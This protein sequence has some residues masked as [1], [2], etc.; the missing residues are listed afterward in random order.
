MESSTLTKK[1]NWLDKL[2]LNKWFW[3][4]FCLFF[5]CY[6]L[7]RSM[8]R[9]LP[10]ELPIYST[11]P[12]YKLIDE[13]G[14][15]FGS[16][17]LKGR[18]YIA[19]FHFT[20]CPSIC[21]KLMENLQ[22]IQKR[23]KGVGQAAAIVA[24][25][26]DPE[27]DTPKVLFNKARELNANPYVWKFLTGKKNELSNLLIDGFKVPMGEAKPVEKNMYDISHAGKLVLVDGAG[28]I[29]GYYSTDRVSIDK[30]MIDLGLLIN[31]SNMKYRKES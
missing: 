3:T 11:L 10:Q 21:P 27:T 30:L 26:V 17:Q 28:K 31:R 6:P 29:R 25:T 16:N 4:V 20:R 15:P 7:Y 23:I 18:V 1:N 13:N 22:Q 14:K 12:D 5:F 2:V 8:N 24:Y 9:E 19:A